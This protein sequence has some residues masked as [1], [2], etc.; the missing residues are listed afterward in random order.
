MS[1]LIDLF[2][3]IAPEGGVS[4]EAAIPSTPL[5]KGHD[6]HIGKDRQGRPL[7]LVSVQRI[8]G[9]A[10]PISYVL[11]N[12]RVDH[13]L[14]CRIVDAT[15][16]DRVASFSII[17]CL[18]DDE[19]LQGF[20]LRTMDALLTALPDLPALADV[21]EAVESLISLFQEIRQPSS[22]PVAGLWGELLL[23]ARSHHLRT[24]LA[25]WH[26]DVFETCDFSSGIERLEVKCAGDRTRRHHFSLEQCHVPA[27]STQLVASLFVEPAAGGLS[28]G[29]L[30]DSVRE[31]V[32]DDPELSLKTDRVC[33]ASLGSSW[34]EARLRRY[35][36]QRA[37]DSLML[38]DSSTIPRIE[39]PVQPGV[40]EVHFRS[41]LGM[42]SSVDIRDYLGG[43]ALFDAI[44]RQR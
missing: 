41:D 35:D 42:A 13:D 36:E 10:I 18:S 44:L 20:F 37:M 19:S 38:F 15:G 16:R 17:K 9:E 11:E 24:A 12:L 32:S 23:I 8:A 33:V 2:T 7:I 3:H 31:G 21:A 14:R 1:T 6:R 39:I 43:N 29:E 30:W 27:G 4:G 25:C 28:L 34:Q 40:S 5:P 22:R 26:N